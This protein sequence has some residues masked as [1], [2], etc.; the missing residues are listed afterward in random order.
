[1]NYIICIKY[2]QFL[3]QTDR[4]HQ[5]KRDKSTN[6]TVLLINKV[7]QETYVNYKLIK[8]PQQIIVWSKTL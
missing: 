6:N 3:F 2:T 5:S 1:M 8:K 7:I 4:Q